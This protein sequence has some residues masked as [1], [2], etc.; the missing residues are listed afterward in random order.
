LTDKTI[1]N[2]NVGPLQL[3]TGLVTVF[4][5]DGKGK[6]TA[7]MGTAVRAVGYGLNVCIIFFF[8]GNMFSQ[9]EV[10]A[11]ATLSNVNICSF[12]VDDWIKSGTGNFAAAEQARQAL[13]EAARAIKSKAYDL[14]IMDEVN[15]AVDFGLI[16][17]QDVL[18][19]LCTRPTDVDVILTGRNASQSII[20]VADIVTEMKCVKH[21][22]ERGIKARQGIDY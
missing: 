9:C 15:N 22:F 4:T 20:E 18:D 13:A 19:V 5:G 14:V 16:E 12:G 17:A 11:L 2:N 6:T 8:K 10:R 21:A 7:A 1:G 3:R